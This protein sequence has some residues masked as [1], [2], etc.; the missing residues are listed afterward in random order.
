MTQEQLDAPAKWIP[1]KE[2]DFSREDCL[3]LHVDTRDFC[4]LANDS[5]PD[6]LY[7]DKAR[8][9]PSWYVHTPEEIVTLLTRLYEESGGPGEWRMLSLE[10][11]AEY[12]TSGWQM[13]YIRIYRYP[14]G[15]LVTSGHMDDH[16]VMN[17]TMLA[18]PVKQEY[19]NHH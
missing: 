4:V 19:L 14:D 1:F 7:V 16:F 12:I 13:K 15:M 17:K 18:C 2:V 5:R 10:G 8:K 6:D 3:A 11:Q 9:N